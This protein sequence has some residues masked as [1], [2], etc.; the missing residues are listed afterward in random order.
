[1]ADELFGLR[2]VSIV[3]L[4]VMAIWEISCGVLWVDGELMD[5]WIKAKQKY[6]HSDAI[7]V[8][9]VDKLFD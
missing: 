8:Q 3:S 5:C 7:L 6:V 9:I 1:M 4:C 2:E